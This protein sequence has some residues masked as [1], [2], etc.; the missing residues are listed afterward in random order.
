LAGVGIFHSEIRKKE[1]LRTMV[2]ESVKP[3]CV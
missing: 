3:M 2:E 1:Q